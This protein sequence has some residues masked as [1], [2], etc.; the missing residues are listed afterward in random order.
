ML[1]RGGVG[2]GGDDEV[3]A[4]LADGGEHAAASG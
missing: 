2:T 3:K 1:G 4:A